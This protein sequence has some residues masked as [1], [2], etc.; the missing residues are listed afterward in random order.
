[1]PTLG[2][3]KD[4]VKSTAKGEAKKQVQGVDVDTVVAQAQAYAARIQ[5]GE[6]Q[7]LAQAAMA[8]SGGPQAAMVYALVQ[9]MQANPDRYHQSADAI[10]SQSLTLLEQE[11]GKPFTWE[12]SASEAW[13]T[14]GD[15]FAQCMAANGRAM[16]GQ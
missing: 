2:D 13:T 1:V 4:L 3:V 11:F 10:A 5:A 14:G 16:A 8:A 9:D 6:P 15:A 12:S 7:A